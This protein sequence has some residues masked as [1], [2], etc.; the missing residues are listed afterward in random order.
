MA[1]TLNANIFPRGLVYKFNVHF[2]LNFNRKNLEIN[3]AVSY[4]MLERQNVY[5]NPEAQNAASIIK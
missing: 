4:C 5:C 1:T 2:V 3:S